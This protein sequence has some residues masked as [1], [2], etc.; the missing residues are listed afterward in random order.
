M[1][2]WT[3]D[4]GCDGLVESLMRALHGD[5][6]AMNY[7]TTAYNQ[8][9]EIPTSPRC[10][11]CPR[12]DE[13]AEHADTL[14]IADVV[15]AHHCRDF[16]KHSTLVRDIL[17]AV[18]RLRLSSGSV[19]RWNSFPPHTSSGRGNSSPRDSIVLE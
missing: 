10:P 13:G 16:A 18:H 11:H 3:N 7:A 5:D 14:A 12:I 6:L 2:A 4:E 1:E 8:T 19:Q 15:G 9:G 17:S